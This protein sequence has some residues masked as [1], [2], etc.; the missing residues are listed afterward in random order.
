MDFSCPQDW[1]WVRFLLT[2]SILAPL[3]FKEYMKRT[4]A[5]PSLCRSRW[6]HGDGDDRH[7]EKY[8]LCLML[9]LFP[10]LAAVNRMQESKMNHTHCSGTVTEVLQC[11]SWLRGGVWGWILRNIAHLP[12]DIFCFTLSDI[13]QL[14]KRSQITMMVFATRLCYTYFC[15]T[16][17]ALK[18]QTLQ[19]AHSH[20]RSNISNYD[21]IISAMTQCGRQFLK[22]KPEM[23]VKPKL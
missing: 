20:H 19:A 16:V 10:E 18:W 22:N 11:D 15:I 7:Q 9:S 12:V 4:C 1:T 14:F 3:F 21:S 2:F 17:N 13:L 8:F 6:K 5:S 23:I